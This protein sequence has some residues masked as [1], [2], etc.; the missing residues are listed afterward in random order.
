[1]V[2][3]ADDVDVERLSRDVLQRF[4]DGLSSRSY[5]SLV[6]ALHKKYRHVETRRCGAGGGVSR[7]LNL[8]RPFKAGNHNGDLTARVASA[9]R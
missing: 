9:T 7:R 2:P 5:T 1:M 3:A 8:A 6:L 4:P